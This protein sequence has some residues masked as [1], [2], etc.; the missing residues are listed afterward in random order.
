VI[1]GFRGHTEWRSP[2]QNGHLLRCGWN[3]QRFLMS[4]VGG[5]LYCFEA[6]YIF[7]PACFSHHFES[8]DNGNL[9]ILQNTPLGTSEMYTVRNEMLELNTRSPN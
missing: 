4:A 3:Q 1:L 2:F 8:G 6:L 5:I 7:H 9:H